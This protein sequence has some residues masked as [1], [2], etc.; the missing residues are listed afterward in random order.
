MDNQKLISV[1][2]PYYN[3]S[4]TLPLALASLLAQTYT[5]WECVIVDD[6]SSDNPASMIERLNDPRIRLYRFEQNRGRG[7]AR[8]QALDL[9]QGDYLCMLDADDWIYPQKLAE[10]IQ[11]M[12]THPEL[13]V[14]GAGLAI[15]DHNQQ[16]AGVR[17]LGAH[18]G[19]SLT[20][21]PP[22]KQ[23]AL[24]PIAHGVCMIR[25][26]IAKATNYDLSLNL[27]EDS[28]FLMTI[29][30]RHPFGVLSNVL[31][32]YSE[33]ESVTLSKVVQSLRAN[34][35]LFWKRRG[36]H[37]LRAYQQIMICLLKEIVYRVMGLLGRFD[38]LIQRRSVAPSPDQQAQF[39]H[40][41]Q[42]VLDHYA[43]HLT[44]S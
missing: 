34:Q 35:Y 36:Q 19:Q 38:R 33:L 22:L 3:A 13:A 25:M 20:Q 23:L 5:N 9:A 8:Q 4:Q 39:D 11:V 24:P 15:V 6:G 26:E 12:E 7:A 32:A 1:I 16:L 28:D 29:L 31:Y 27:S 18:Q 21:H 42:I 17:V 40:A 44:R 10:Q 37:P 41:K 30:A 43:R 14:L 2:T